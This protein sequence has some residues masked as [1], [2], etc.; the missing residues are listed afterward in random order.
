MC[1]LRPCAQVLL[2]LV[3]KFMKL[4]DKRALHQFLRSKPEAVSMSFL[5]WVADLEAQASGEQKQVRRATCRRLLR[6]LHCLW[7][8]PRS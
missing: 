2:A 5:L 1:S 4:P 8:C 3:T 7:L 6:L